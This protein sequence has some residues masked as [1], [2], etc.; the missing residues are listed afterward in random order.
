METDKVEYEDT[1]NYKIYDNDENKTKY[2]DINAIGKERMKEQMDEINTHFSHPIYKVIFEIWKYCPSLYI[3]YN[4]FYKTLPINAHLFMLFTSYFYDNIEFMIGHINLHKQFCTYPHPDDA[5]KNMNPFIS[6]AYFHH[7]FNPQALSIGL[8][9]PQTLLIYLGHITINKAKNINSLH[10]YKITRITFLLSIIYGVHKLLQYYFDTK[11]TTFMAC[12]Y[13]SLTLKL[14]GVARF[15]LWAIKYTVL[16]YFTEN[17]TM[18]NVYIAY[19][20]FMHLLQAVAHSWYHT[21]K[22]DRQNFGVFLYHLSTLLELTGI[23]NTKTHTRHHTHQKHNMKDAEHWEDM[24]MPPFVSDLFEKI[25]INLRDNKN[26]NTS[27]T[28]VKLSYLLSFVVVTAMCV[29]FK[30]I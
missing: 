3:I 30:L 14:A 23:Y 26:Y 29:F 4:I 10:R 24:I 20:A 8:M 21:L 19:M 12:V 2:T 1:T 6:L 7:Y 28:I 9:S 27:F 11:Y 16:Y 18:C 15:R 25:W 17:I 13:F 22:K 5:K